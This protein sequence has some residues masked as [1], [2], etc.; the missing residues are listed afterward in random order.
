MRA[1]SLSASLS[2]CASLFLMG[3]GGE[4]TP[5]PA[6][7]ATPEAAPEAPPAPEAAPEVPEVDWATLD[8]AGKKKHLMALGKV[9][10][11]TGGKGGLACVTCHQAD[12]KGTPG[13]FPPLVGQKEHMGDC[14]KHAGIVLNGLTGEIVVDGVKYNGVMVPMKDLLDDLSIAAVMTFERNSWGNDYGDCM[15]ETVAEV[16]KLAE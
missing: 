6:P 13:A 14:A 5:A 12:G 9:I 2:V 3:C 11:E 15:P 4:S 1:L 16:R 10:Y 7:D 8:D